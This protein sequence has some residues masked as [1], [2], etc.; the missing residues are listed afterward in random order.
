MS[1]DIQQPTWISDLHTP[2]WLGLLLVALPL[3]A[4]IAFLSYQST[5]VLPRISLAPSFSLLDQNG[6]RLTSEALRGT[7]VLYNVSHTRCT[8]PCVDSSL[9]LQQLQQTLAD[10]ETGGI[11]LHFVTISSDPV[12][13][14]PQTL[15]GYAKQLGADT[16]KWSFVSGD[17]Q[18]ISHIL[19]AGFQ[20]EAVSDVGGSFTDE[21]FVALVD[22]WGIVR[23]VYRTA[24]PDLALIKDDLELVAREARSNTG[25]NRYAYEAV[26]L[27]MCHN[28]LY[29][30]P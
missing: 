27:F 19:K 28:D 12:Y 21:P 25:V 11:P 29:T 18:Q 2:R 20:S 9:T 13:D 10:V 1:T 8:A 14:T 23:A 30:Q 5:Q 6:E 15:F 22:G 26:H 16:E 4:I 7:L 3:V 24:T 17:P